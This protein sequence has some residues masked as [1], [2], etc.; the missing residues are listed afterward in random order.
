[1]EVYRIGSA[2]WFNNRNTRFATGYKF[3]LQT[4]KRPTRGRFFI[5]GSDGYYR[6]VYL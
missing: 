2:S 1:M 6:T 5:F 3:W 4:K